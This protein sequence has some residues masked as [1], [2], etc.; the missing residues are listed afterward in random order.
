MQQKNSD[1]V[2]P[3]EFYISAIVNKIQLWHFN[4][5]L[6]IRFSMNLII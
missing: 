5:A 3:S 2:Y 4:R 1:K 6:I